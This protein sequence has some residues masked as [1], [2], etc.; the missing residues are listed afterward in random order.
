MLAIKI[1]SPTFIVVLE[2]MYTVFPSFPS[3]I[4]ITATT[5]EGFVLVVEELVLAVEPTNVISV[6]EFQLE[7]EY[8]ANTFDGVVTTNTANN[9]A[10]I[11][12]GVGERNLFIPL[13]D[14]PYF[15]LS[16]ILVFRIMDIKYADIP[17]IIT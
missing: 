2:G 9:V 8:E 3:E 5:G 13:I 4:V 10:N 16:I 11:T 14:T 6:L 1:S 17:I 15:M 12:V 7:L